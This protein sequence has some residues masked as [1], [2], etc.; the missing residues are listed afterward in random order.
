MRT[1][2]ILGCTPLINWDNFWLWYVKPYLYRLR[3][4]NQNWSRI[5]CVG[6][7]VGMSS[8]RNPF[9]I[10]Q[11]IWDQYPAD[12]LVRSVT[13]L[14][15]DPLFKWTAVDRQWIWDQVVWCLLWLTRENNNYTWSLI[16]LQIT[17]GIKS[18]RGW[19]WD[20]EWEKSALCG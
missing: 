8:R 3:V 1:D 6:N 15:P 2:G 5:H 20:Q 13:G 18:P 16:Q 10:R 14:I 19:I 12:I 7:G 9:A 4:M 17:C 11:W